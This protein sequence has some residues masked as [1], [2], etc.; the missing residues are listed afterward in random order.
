MVRELPGGGGRGTDGE[1][2]TQDGLQ[3]GEARGLRR[4][5]GGKEIKL[6]NNNK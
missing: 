1:G 4:G 2:H 5:T 6:K 3:Q